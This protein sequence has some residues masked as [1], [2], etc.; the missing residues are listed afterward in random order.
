MTGLAIAPNGLANPK[1]IP[2]YPQSKAEL[3]GRDI[4][5]SNLQERPITSLKDLVI[6]PQTALELGWIDIATR[7][8]LL[9]EIK[10]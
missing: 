10:R 9:K 4:A 5:I 1:E 6:G 7:D 8:Q 2:L 3:M